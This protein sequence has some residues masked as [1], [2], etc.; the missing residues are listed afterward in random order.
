LHQLY[1]VARVEN[2]LQL[3]RNNSFIDKYTH[4]ITAKMVFHSLNLRAFCITSFELMYWPSKFVEPKVT[5][6]SN[7]NFNTYN[8]YSKIR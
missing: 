7:P 5:N 1:F 6:H 4:T 3:L 2:D 8:M